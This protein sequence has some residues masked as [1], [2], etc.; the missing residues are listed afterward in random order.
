MK[1]EKRIR[2]SPDGPRCRRPLRMCHAGDTNHRHFPRGE[3]A[4]GVA[5]SF[6]ETFLLPRDRLTKDDTYIF[7]K[8][9]I[10][11]FIICQRPRPFH[12]T[13]NVCT[14]LMIPFAKQTSQSPQGN[15]LTLPRLLISSINVALCVARGV[16]GSSSHPAPRGSWGQFPGSSSQRGNHGNRPS[17]GCGEDEQSYWTPLPVSVLG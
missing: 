15:S 13:W 12:G 4:G 16:W 1:V 10:S 8:P 3:T 17:Q 9:L 7:L 14:H 5:R 2:G 6:G 11:S